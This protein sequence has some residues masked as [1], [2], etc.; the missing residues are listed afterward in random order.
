MTERF[1]NHYNYVISFNFF[2]AYGNCNR[3]L[4]LNAVELIKQI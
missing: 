3:E 1:I 4:E 2:D